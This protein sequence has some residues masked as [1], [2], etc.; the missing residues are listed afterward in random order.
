MALTAAWKEAQRAVIGSLMLAPDVCAGEVFQK[1]LPEHFGDAALRHVFEAARSLWERNKPID[2]VTVAA[3]SGADE[4]TKLIADCM[5]S[6]PTSENVSAWL[7]ILRS[8]ARISAL[9][10]EALKIVAEDV[11]EEQALA[12]YERMG[13]LLRGMGHAEHLTLEQLICDYLDRMHDPT[14]PDYLKWGIEKIDRFLNVSPGMFVILAADSS[15]GKTALAL[16]F[17]V[18]IA[19]TGKRVGF[20]SIETV[21]ESL[22]D[23]L[24]AE[25]QLAGIP[26]PSTKRKQLTESHFVEAGKVGM[27]AASIPFCIDRHITTLQGIRSVILMHRYEVVFV[28]YVQLIEIPGRERWEIVTDISMGLHRMAQELGVTIVGLSQITPPSKTQGKKAGRPTKDDLR[29][30][31]Q[32]KQDAEVIMILS[33]STDEGDPQNTRILEVAKNKDNRCGAIKLRFEPELM[34]FSELITISGMRAEGQAIK[35]QRIS[36][37]KRAIREENSR[38]EAA[39]ENTKSGELTELPEDDDTYIPF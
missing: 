20:I 17:G 16:Q 5:R 33:P 14:P 6:T 21:K 9:Q 31:K 1:A 27:R 39:L 18:H 13:E 24:M 19:T 29:E 26:L 11:S 35:N 37:G 7:E 34:T 4:Y 8:K 28:D 15:V 23:R 36:E 38:A 12:A 10:S 22:E 30:S 25:K 3:A 32:L 2:P